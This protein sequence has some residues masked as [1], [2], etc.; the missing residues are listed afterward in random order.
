VTPPEKTAPRTARRAP[1]AFLV[2]T[3]ILL[4]RISGL[5]QRSVFAHFFGDSAAADAYNAAFRI[6]NFLQTLFGEGVLSASF[7]PVYAKLVATNDEEEAHRVAGAI[8]SLLAALVAVIVLVGILT[9]PYMIWAIAPGFTGDRRELTIQ[10][11]RIFFPGI[12]LLVLSAWCLGILNSHHRFFISYTAPVAMN[13]VVLVTL[14]VFGRRRGQFDLAAITAWG[15]VAG[16]LL[17]IAVQMPAVLKLLRGLPL[18]FEYASANVR[19]VVVNFVPVF[20]SKGVVQLSAYVDQIICSYLPQ[21]AVAAL[22][23]AQLLYLLPVSLFGMAVSAAELP[24][25]SGALGDERQVA[26]YLAQRLN[27]GLRQIAFF[28]VPS[29]MA[30]LAFGDVLNGAIFQSGVFTRQTA[31]Y[32]WGILAGSTVGLLAQTM[33]RLYSSAYYAMRDT[34]TPLR[35]AI[36]RVILTT[37]LGYLAAIPIPLKLGIDPRWGVAGLTASAGI[38]G[39]VEFSLLRHTLNRR[40]GKTGLPAPF[41]V[42]LWASA[43]LAAGLGWAIKLGVGQ[44]NPRLMAVLVLGPYGV[45]YF[46]FT[47]GLKVKEARGAIDRVA[48]MLRSGRAGS[49]S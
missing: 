15:V 14:L 35:Y 12:G 48:R 28:V 18:V 33:G 31:V 16:S 9:A 3:G 45:A 26:A 7:I 24:A 46:G 39:W 23:Y 4:S 2:A 25:M 20:V 21:G 47:A 42:K 44:H 1:P 5:L 40:I 19:T 10:L 17:Q 49:R 29:V 41:V 38:A 22:A 11:V 13:L 37:V 30:F 36:I 8:L 34:R 27:Y 6:P 43:L 32:V